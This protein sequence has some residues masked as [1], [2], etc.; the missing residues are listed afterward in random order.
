[1]VRER[2]GGYAFKDR[3]DLVNNNKRHRY[4][5]EIVH[6]NDFRFLCKGHDYAAKKFL[7]LCRTRWTGAND[8]YYG[9]YI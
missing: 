2:L 9:K 7:V 1:M 4:E 5:T 6:S 3:F 8:R